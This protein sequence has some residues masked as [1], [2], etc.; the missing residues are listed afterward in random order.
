MGI[1]HYSNNIAK[2]CNNNIT[3]ASL[4]HHILYWV[5]KNKYLKKMYYDEQ[6][7][8]YQSYQQLEKRFE[9]LTKRQIA[10]SLKKLEEKDLIKSTTQYCNESSVGIFKNTKWYTITPKGYN[11]LGED[12]QYVKDQIEGNRVKKEEKDKQERL[13]KS[14]KF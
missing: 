2:E 14:M 8:V 13:W 6:Y 3:C 4:F 9:C 7:W 10:F 5:E 11:I 12:I 1:F